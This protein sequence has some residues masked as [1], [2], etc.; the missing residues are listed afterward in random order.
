MRKILFVAA[1]LTLGF[2][3]A[4]AQYGPRYDHRDDRRDDRH[5]GQVDDR[6]YDINRMQREVRED[7]SFG[8]RRGTL[9]PR[10]SSMLMREYD[11]IEAMQR[12]FSHRGR[13][14]NREARI[15]RSELQRLSADTHRLT[16]NRNGNW[17]RGRRY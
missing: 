1:M 5:H 12:K 4:N 2:V 9:N 7:I 11:R 13:L 3:N 6:N 17:A 16:N 8:M 10:E 15:L 14:S